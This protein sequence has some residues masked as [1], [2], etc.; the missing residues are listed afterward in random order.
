M[1]GQWKSTLPLYRR[2]QSSAQKQNGWEI[3]ILISITEHHVKK[4]VKVHLHF[5][6]LSTDMYGHLGRGLCAWFIISLAMTLHLTVWNIQFLL[7]HLLLFCQTLFVRSYEKSWT[8]GPLQA[9]SLQATKLI[10]PVSLLSLQPSSVWRL[11]LGPK[12]KAVL[13]RIITATLSSKS[14]ETMCKNRCRIVSLLQ[15]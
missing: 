7:L 13:G 3:V 10:D 4:I 5:S 9:I 11:S 15:R 6:I 14:T 8:S 2:F 1:H 12:Q